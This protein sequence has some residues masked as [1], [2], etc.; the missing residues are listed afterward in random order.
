MQEAKQT[1]KKLKFK[2]STGID[3]VI[4]ELIKSLN[5]RALLVIL[6][7]LNKIFKSGEFP[8]EW[9]M[10]IIV[11]IFKAGE[12]E[13]LNNYRG[14]TLLNIVGKVFVGILN[15]RLNKFAEKFNIICENQAGFRKSYRTTDHILTLH[16]I[17]EHFLNVK[18]KPLYVCFVDFKKAFDKVSHP[19]LWKKLISYQVLVVDFLIP[20]GQCVVR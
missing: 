20:F 3:K 1:L 4:A 11:P 5:H 7:I 16:A 10:G 19:I 6:K 9:A 2:K 18:K 13:D 17:V 15:E 8:E 12:R 14:I